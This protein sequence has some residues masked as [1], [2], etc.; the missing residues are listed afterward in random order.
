MPKPN[1]DLLAPQPYTKE[2]ANYRHYE[3]CK[4][5]AFFNGRVACSK[6]KGHIAPD[7][8]CNFWALAEVMPG[9][10]GKEIIETEY[11]KSQSVKGAE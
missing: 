5:C 11:E 2:E 6:V 1:L 7:A 10:T 9:L 4:T 8:V 3:A